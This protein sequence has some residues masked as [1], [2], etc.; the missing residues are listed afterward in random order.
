MDTVM[1]EKGIRTMEQVR[2]FLEGTRYNTQNR[3]TFFRFNIAGR[4]FIV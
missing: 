2:Q 3:L 1:N 4:D